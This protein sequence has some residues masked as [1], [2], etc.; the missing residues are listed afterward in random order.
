MLM[1]AIRSGSA[2][3]RLRQRLQGRPDAVTVSC[4]SSIRDIRQRRR[5]LALRDDFRW[6]VFGLWLVRFVTSAYARCCGAL[7]PR[8]SWTTTMDSDQASAPGCI[9]VRLAVF[10]PMTKAR[11]ATPLAAMPPSMALPGQRSP[12]RC[13]S[14]PDRT[15]ASSAESPRGALYNA[16]SSLDSVSNRCGLNA[17][18]ARQ[19]KQTLPSR[20]EI[21]VPLRLPCQPPP[22]LPCPALP[23]VPC[24]A[25][26]CPAAPG[27]A[28]LAVP[29]LAAPITAKPCLPTQPPAAQATRT[30]ARL[31][32]R[33]RT[34]LAKYHACARESSRRP[35]A[36]NWSPSNL[37]R[38]I[39]DH[40]AT[41]GGRGCRQRRSGCVPTSS[42]FSGASA[43]SRT[44]GRAVHAVGRPSASERPLRRASS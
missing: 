9:P 23:A 1:R 18:R 34:T 31:I 33:E 43:M 24:R 35:D 3:S 21:A 26:P 39:A 22:A 29:C 6:N 13:G 4:A 37:T 27:L 36:V 38:T 11:D 30:Q 25:L 5:T 2:L 19:I 15:P 28:C 14:F 12:H 20:L 42:V 17:C 7:L 44:K 41:S 40:C 10:R 8:S 16:A 32:L